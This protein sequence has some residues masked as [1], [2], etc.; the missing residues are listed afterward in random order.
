MHSEARSIQ[1][2]VRRWLAAAWL[3][4]LRLRLLLRGRDGIGRRFHDHH[5]RLRGADL[6]QSIRRGF[7]V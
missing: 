6:Q 4:A 3:H 2:V 7:E 1:I 5:D